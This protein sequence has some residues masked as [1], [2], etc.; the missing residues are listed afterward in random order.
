[1]TNHSWLKRP[2]VWLV[3]VG[4]V[5]I[6]LIEGFALSWGSGT[7]SGSSTPVTSTTQPHTLI[8]IP[9]PTVELCPHTTAQLIEVDYLRNPGYGQTASVTGHVV[10][11]HCGGPDDFQFIV[12]ATPV[13]V[14]LRKDAEIV[15]MNAEPSYYV[16]DLEQLNDYLSVDFDGNIFA[17]GGSDSAATE[18]LAQ[19]HP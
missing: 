16:G 10:T 4:V 7:S 6:V 8:T 18:L 3:L 9:E 15:L 17:V 11:V 19:F 2:T 14:T 1:M 5:A 12:H 13:T